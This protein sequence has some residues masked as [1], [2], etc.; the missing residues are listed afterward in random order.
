MAICTDASIY[1]PFPTLKFNVY[2]IKSLQGKNN[3]NSVWNVYPQFMLNPAVIW[4]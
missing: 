4:L 1:S 2:S 3:K